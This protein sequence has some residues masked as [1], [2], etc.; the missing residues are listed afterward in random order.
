MAF[1]VVKRNRYQHPPTG[2][3]PHASEHH[4][5]DQEEFHRPLTRLDSA[6]LRGD[7]GIAD[8]L[9]VSG[10]PGATAVVIAAGAAVDKP[11]ETI[12]L[13]AT[14]R[15]FI[16]TN[17]PGALD[18]SDPTVPTVPVSLPLGTHSGQTVYVT[19]KFLESSSSSHAPTRA[20][21]VASSRSRGCGCSRP[22]APPPP[23]PM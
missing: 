11:G 19:I 15:G 10:A 22:P 1:E 7:W 3:F 12:V 14:G 16:G 6:H 2:Y 5:Q 9:E 20:V 17:P 13:P 4:Y 23:A 18:V 8:G 21:V